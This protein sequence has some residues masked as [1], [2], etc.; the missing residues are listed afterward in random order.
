MGLLDAGWGNTSIEN[1]QNL[2][3]DP[4]AVPMMAATSPFLGLYGA[5][6]GVWP[7]AVLGAAAGYGRGNTSE[8]LGRGMFRGIGT[9]G[10]AGLGLGLGAALGTKLSN[11][12][13][14]GAGLGALAGAIGGGYLGNK[15][16]GKLLG[17]PV[18]DGKKETEKRAFLGPLLSHPA[19]Q[20]MGQRLSNF[21]VPGFAS[22]WPGTGSLFS[23]LGGNS[24]TAAPPPGPRDTP[25][26]SAIWNRYAQLGYDRNTFDANRRQVDPNIHGYATAMQR[27]NALPAR[28]NPYSPTAI[29]EGPTG[30]SP[31]PSASPPSAATPPAM[32]GGNSSASPAG[33]AAAPSA[34]PNAFKPKPPI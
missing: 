25:E 18:G 33:H 29:K 20:N 17:K 26:A 1:L 22:P 13:P 15:A 3:F 11:G 10:G 2:R 14:G 7:G 23:R 5:G 9:G 32:F 6:A 34:M 12:N 19:V 31:A 24:G 8:G 16:V 21:S 4:R 28:H 30:T 27:V